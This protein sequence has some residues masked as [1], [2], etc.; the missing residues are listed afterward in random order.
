M[1]NHIV[2][3]TALLLVPV[4]A[5]H[6]AEPKP[7]IVL[8]LADD[9]G[10]SDLGCYGADLHETPH[11]DQLAKQGVRFTDAY[12]M[13]VC[14]PSRAALLTG[15]HAARLHMTIWSE[16]SKTG[17]K[18][19]KLIEADSLHDL[20]HTETTLAQRLQ[21]AGYLTALVGKWHLGDA[22]HYPETH[23][24]DVNIGGTQWGAPQTFFWPYSGSGRFGPE[25]RY[26]PHL[27]FGKPGEYLTDRLTDE[28]LRVIDHGGD[29]P[30]F[31]YF[32]HYAPHTPMEAKAHDVRHFEAKLRPGQHHQ[33][34][35]YAAMVK[36]LDDSV[37]RVLAHLKKQGLEQNTIV[38]FTSDNGGY[39]GTEKGQTMPVTSNAPLR[40]GKGSLYE[41]G[42]RVPLIVRW[43]G[44]TPEAAECRQPVILMDLFHTLTATLSNAK[45]NGIADGIDLKALL[46]NPVT[47][48]NRD[49]L[50]F[51]YPHYYPTTTPVSAIRYGD[52]KLLEYLEDCRRELYNLKDDP[53]EQTDL[54]HRMPDKAASLLKQLHDW[55]TEVKAAIPTPNPNFK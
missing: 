43:P 48:L 44:V 30:F 1:R 13:S 19:R 2:F 25:F 22:A 47:Q 9:L 38:I 54:A 37:G 51:H 29:Q 7:N 3:L 15:K 8:I 23:G 14:T 17:P 21:K 34:A 55:R 39:I 16:G 6:A 28:A 53:G 12:A 33:N 49:A 32:A 35:V 42:I 40:S 50:Y 46:E 31:L 45:P 4:S 20:P 10:W 52:W 27:E 26:V 18:K 24:F 5:F 36:S 11:L 41:G